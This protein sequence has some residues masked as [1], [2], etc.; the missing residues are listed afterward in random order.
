MFAFKVYEK[1]GEVLLAVADSDIVGKKFEEGDICIDVDKNFYFDKRCEESKIKDMIEN[2]TIVNAVGNK[3][4]SLLLKSGLIKD[5][6]VLS[7]NGVM[8]AQIVKIQ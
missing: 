6:N 4:V 3:I 7:I 8:H 1:D 2:S 5:G